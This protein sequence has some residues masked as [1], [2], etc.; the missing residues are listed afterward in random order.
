[1]ALFIGAYELLCHVAGNPQLLGQREGPLT[2]DD[3][4]VDGLGLTPHLGGDHLREQPEH[5]TGSTGMDILVLTEGITEDRILREMG[6]HPQLD[7]GVVGCQNHA[8]G[9]CNERLADT[10]AFVGTDR[11]ILQVGI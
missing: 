4:E 5:L 1:M 7:L 8:T 9:R 10:A 6:Q 3:A 2:V 11:D